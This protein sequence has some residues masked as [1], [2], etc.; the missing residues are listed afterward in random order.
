MLASIAQYF[1]PDLQ[2]NELRKFGLLSGIF[3][4]II[5]SYWL[6]RELKDTIFMKIAFPEQLGW[7]ANQGRLFQPNAKFWS[8]FVVIA[9]VLL[10]SKL[11]DLF[12]KHQLFY[13]VCGFYSV[14]FG[15]VTLVL[16]WKELYGVE[17][18]GR[19]LLA[20]TGWISYFAIESYGSLV[21]NAVF[22]SFTNSIT[23][24][25]AAKRGFPLVIACAQ[26]GAISVSILMILAEHIGAIWPLMTIATTFVAAI[27]VLVFYFMKTTPAHDMVGNPAAHKT[28][29]KKEGFFEGFVAGLV[30][31]TTRPYLL[32]VLAVSTIY[33]IAKTVVDYQMKA[34]AGEHPMF[35]TE[36]GF[37]KFMG[38]FGFCTNGLAF[39]MALLGTSHLMKKYG[40]RV[41]LL[42]YPICFA[43]A[44][45]V[46]LAYN[47][48]A[49]PSAAAMLWAIFGV[50]MFVTGLSYAVNNPTKEMMYIPTS[51]DAKYKAKSWTDAFGART[52][53]ATGARISNIFKH[54]LN[55]LL[56]Y[57]SMISLGLIGIWT[58]A[59]IFV[60]LKNAQLIRD[61]EIVE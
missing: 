59:A 61:N 53:K 47:Y 8:V 49:N 12:K 30:L 38:M 10:Y 4:L 19:T 48:F 34:L 56:I 2:Q 1:Y 37:A 25:N 54:D 13:V 41:C 60:G 17:S 57:G 50:M 51:K 23:D 58:I 20:A 11:V 16:L 45:I 9:V 32:G 6:L 42:V 55:A 31:L 46:L 26:L 33:E 43:L 14:V 39:L 3:T 40:L 36:T 15:F 27:I 35:A 21:V 29:K 7:A 52:A 28:E 44:L 5:G 22:W 18:V 24:S